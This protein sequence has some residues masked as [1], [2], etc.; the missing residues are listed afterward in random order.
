MHIRILFVEDNTHKREK[1]VAYLREIS[2]GVHIVE[3][4]SF[5]SGCQRL[6]EQEYD[7]VLLDISLPTYD[8]GAGE[9]GGRF[10]TFGG[11]EIARKIVRSGKR[12]MILF[13]TQ[14]ESF[15]DK[16]RW[17]ALAL[18]QLGAELSEDC[19]E[20]YRGLIFYDSSKASWKDE[21]RSAI[22]S[23]KK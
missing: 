7:L 8:K 22:E 12:T 11:R 5:A 17:G 3:A 2:P 9:S 4:H 19:N 23:V 18:E 20:M 16:Q 10:R 13:I 1:I 6:L 21:L 15:S 14:Y